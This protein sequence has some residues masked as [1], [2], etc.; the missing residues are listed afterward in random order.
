M[1]ALRFAVIGTG[2]WSTYQI[3]V[4]KELAG[5]ELVAVYNRTRAR[6]EEVAIK[7]GMPKV[8]DSAGELLQKV[9]HISW[10]AAPVRY[11]S[12]NATAFVQ[13]CPC[14]TDP[15]SSDGHYRFSRN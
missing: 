2:F 7:F 14:R 8:Y 1:K 10:C 4:W 12:Q 3:P 13:R 6:A 5:V 11:A 9:I 15:H